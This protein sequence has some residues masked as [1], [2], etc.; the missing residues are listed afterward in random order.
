MAVRLDG[1]ARST[2]NLLNVL[3]GIARLGAGSK[4]LRDQY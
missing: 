2:M 3:D 4:S 1:L